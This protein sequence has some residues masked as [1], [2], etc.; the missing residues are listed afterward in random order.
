MSA[1]TRPW[2][3]PKHGLVSSRFMTAIADIHPSVRRRNLLAACAA[4]IVFGFAMGLSYPLLSL[5]LERRGVSESVIGMNAA[6]SPLGILM[7]SVF[8]PVLA[9]RFG[10]RTVT[11]SAAFAAALIMLCYRVFPSLEAWFVL[12]L[13]HGMVVST[14]FVLSESWVVKYADPGSRG[15]VVAIYGAALAASFGAGPLLISLIGI[16]GWLPFAIGAGVLVA[17]TVP[18]ALIREERL[19]PEAH[20]GWG[21]ILAFIPKAPILLAAVFIFAVFDAATLSLIPVYGVRLGYDLAAA[22]N[23]LTVLIVGNVILLLPIGWLIDHKDRRM[24][25]AGLGAVTLALLLVLPLV[26]GTWVQWPA[27]FMVGATGYGIYTCA[28]A[29]LGDRYTGHQLI[30]GSSSFATMWGSGALA[31]SLIAGGAMQAMGPHGL[32]LSL[33][34][35][36]GVFLLGMWLRRAQQQ[37]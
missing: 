19:E 7:F 24:V 21:D 4:I 29:I 33:A 28:L 32:P 14:L 15:K 22:S 31:G 23:M 36:F 3:D 6:M 20:A 37:A 30:A 18:I 5:L 10:A 26:A 8:I 2:L 9:R 35:C 13:A 27:L 1:L 16:D 12:R 17:A 25:M 11:I 34:V